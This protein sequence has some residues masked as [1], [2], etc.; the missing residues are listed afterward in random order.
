MFIGW[1]KNSGELF[2]DR[3]LRYAFAFRTIFFCFLWWN[4]KAFFSLKTGDEFYETLAARTYF[5]GEVLL[6]MCGNFAEIAMQ[7]PEHFSKSLPDSTVMKTAITNFEESDT[8][9]D[10]SHSGK[11]RFNESEER[12]S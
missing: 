5:D 4:V 1:R 2:D 8:A 12:K 3:Y 9:E 10:A 11:L 6:Q 7:W